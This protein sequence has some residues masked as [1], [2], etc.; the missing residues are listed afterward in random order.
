[1]IIGYVS[2]LLLAAQRGHAGGRL[3][4]V[5]C[6]TGDDGVHPDCQSEQNGKNNE[7]Q[8]KGAAQ[9][10]TRGRFSC[11]GES[12]CLNDSHANGAGPAPGSR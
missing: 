10:S 8:H 4:R 7:G 6:G 3:S 9:G 2:D 5:D 1:M 11:V 12:R